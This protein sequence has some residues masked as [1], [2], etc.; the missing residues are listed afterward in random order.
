MNISQA[1]MI[2]FFRFNTA[3]G[4][5]RRLG[6]L[7]DYRGRG[8]PLCCRP[9][10]DREGGVQDRGL[11]QDEARSRPRP[12]WQRRLCARGTD[13]HDNSH[14]KFPQKLKATWLHNV[15]RGS[16]G[17]TQGFVTRFPWSSTD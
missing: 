11:H 5:W 17:L 8:E 15:Q 3:A 4:L 13:E 9:G 7:P 1:E 6:I 14:E 12:G 2:D 10:R 16:L